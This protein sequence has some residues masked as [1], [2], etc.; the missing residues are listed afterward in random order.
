MAGK[1]RLKVLKQLVTSAPAIRKQRVRDAGA[2]FTF[3][4]LG[5]LRL[6]NPGNDHAHREGGSSS[7]DLPNKM[8][9][10]QAT[11]APEGL[12]LYI[13]KKASKDFS[14]FNRVCVCMYVSVGGYVLMPEDARGWLL[15]SWCSRQ[16]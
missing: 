15:P 8:P 9:C 16:L 2:Q 7:I 3:S 5:S 12:S 10:R 14:I 6:P 4:I 1:L 13:F 11:G